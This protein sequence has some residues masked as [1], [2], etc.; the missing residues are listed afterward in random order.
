MSI[1]TLIQWADCTCN[2][3]MGCTGCELWNRNRRSCYAGVQHEQFGEVRRGFSP[4]F[5]QITFWPG[6]MAT[7]A[8]LPDLSGRRHGEKSWLDGQPRLIFVSDMGDALCS[9][10]PFEYLRQ[11]V[12]TSVT[13]S[14][15]RRHRW[16]WLTKR[17]RRMAKFSAWL[18][19]QGIPWPRN[20]WAGT[21]V[22]TADTTSRINEL[23]D[24]GTDAT[25]HFLSA[26]PQLESLDLSPWLPRLDWVI[27]GG[28][29]GIQPR[30]F[31]I[32]WAQT[33]FENC[34]EAAT[35]FFLKQLGGYVFRGEHRVR[36]QD[37]HGGDW[38]EW[39]DDVP[40][41][42][43]LPHAGLLQGGWVAC[44]ERHKEIVVEGA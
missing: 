23:L 10:V 14:R 19:A 40:R 4:D 2:P 11:E 37:R 34:Q 18:A 35:P 17:P 3:V 43:Q 33:M 29:S 30:K 5:S 20:L 7:A 41:L 12:I 16:L 9:S 36:L 32:G 42:R 25:I 22:T 13:G 6:R 24:V 44:A 31:E 38:T 21:T 28:E 39:P 15:G 8:A 27:Q 1:S 26:E